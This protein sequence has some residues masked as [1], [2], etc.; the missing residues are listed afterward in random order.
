MELNSNPNNM[1]PSSLKEWKEIKAIEK[2][3]AKFIPF[4]EKEKGII[5]PK[6]IIINLDNENKTL[7]TKTY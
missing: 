4:R 7:Q 3:A 5:K 2:E 6:K 1:L